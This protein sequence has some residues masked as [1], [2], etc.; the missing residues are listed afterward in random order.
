MTHI[1]VNDLCEVAAIPEKLKIDLNR[2]GYTLDEDLII[3][4]K[5]LDGTQMIST[6]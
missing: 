6:N 5:N 3:H 2:F 1:N 4:I